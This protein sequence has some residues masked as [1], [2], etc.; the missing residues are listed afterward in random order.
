MHSP[1]VA[2]LMR[3][4]RSQMDSLI[5]GLPHDGMNTMALGLAHR[6]V[7]V[8]TTLNGNP[9]LRYLATYMSTV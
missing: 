1:A 8:C 6:Y 9:Y 5:P 4:I 3:C 7:H 2:E